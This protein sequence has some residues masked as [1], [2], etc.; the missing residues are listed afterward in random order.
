MWKLV[1]LDLSWYIVPTEGT[2]LV[3]VSYLGFGTI[4]SDCV[5]CGKVVTYSYDVDWLFL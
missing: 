4:K 3:P 2:K 1:A 5:S